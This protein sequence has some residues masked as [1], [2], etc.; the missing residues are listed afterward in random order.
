M[1]LHHSNAIS[2]DSARRY[3]DLAHIR[4]RRRGNVKGLVESWQRGSGRA[5]TSG[6]ESSVSGSDAESEG[7]VD[8]QSGAALHDESSSPAETSSP[9]TMADST[10]ILRNPPPPYTSLAVEDEDE[11]TMEE[12]LASSA[13]LQGARAWEADVGLGETVKHISIASV[14]PDPPL[15]RPTGSYDTGEATAV[16]KDSV[17]PNGSREGTGSR[18]RNTRN[19][20]RVVTAIF[21]GS[22]SAQATDMV[23]ELGEDPD[24]V[25]PN[26]GDASG[27]ELIDTEVQGREAPPSV[28]QSVDE[29]G[30]VLCALE[31]SLAATRAQ[32]ESFRLRLEAVEA[33]TARHEAELQRV[34]QSILRDSTSKDGE[35]NQTHTNP[36]I[37]NIPPHEETKR[38]LSEGGLRFDFGLRDI[39]R[40]IVTR[41]IGWVFPYS[42]PGLHTRPEQ[43]RAVHGRSRDGNQSPVR[44]PP[45]P[46][47][48]ITYLVWFSFA[49]C[50][51][52]LRRAGFGRWVRR[53]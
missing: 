32:L 40:S 19:Q 47:L 44:R 22:P 51:A 53:P 45:L 5:S 1:S 50:A 27:M 34:A 26:N 17:L 12:L 46:A 24:L 13:P 20:K 6:S 43:S 41:A 15:S 30:D 49:I 31:D 23:P 10:I 38:E 2:E 52:I 8:E 9:A 21:T 11:L 14:S 7:S 42:H 35:P 25:D 3:R 37:E 48:R 28:A 33:D 18:G 39:A 4:T 29:S 16:Q 36:E